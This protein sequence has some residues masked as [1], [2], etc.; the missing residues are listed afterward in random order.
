MW[1]YADGTHEFIDGEIY[2]HDGEPAS[3][4]QR[5]MDVYPQSERQEV[6]G[7]RNEEV[8]RKKKRTRKQKQRNKLIGFV[9]ELVFLAVVVVLLA[10]VM[11]FAK[12]YNKIGVESEFA[13]NSEAGINSEIESEH[14]QTLKGYTNIALFGLDNRSA[15]NYSQGRSDSIMIAS[16]NNETKEVKLVSVFRDTY[17]SV[18]NGKFR[19]ANT[20]YASGGAKQAVQMLNSNLDLNITEYVC[21]D[22]AALIEAIDALG[23]VEIEV[24]KAEVKWINSYVDEMH[25]VI[26][27]NGKHVKQ[28]GLQTLNGTQAT[29]Y[30]RIRYTSGD[31]FKRASRQRIVLGAM[32]EKAK[33]S[34]VNTLLDICEAVFDDIST[35][36]TLPEILNL[37]TGVM[38]Y[39]LTSTTGFP[40]EVTTRTI[41]GNGDTVV[42]IMLNANVSRLHEYMFGTVGYKPSASV[43]AI[44]KAI[45]QKTGVNE[46]TTPINTDKFNDTAG[47]DG[48]D[49]D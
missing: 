11:K 27:A 36:L 31:D 7:N 37:A 21:V 19:K 8:K 15:G 28:S 16:I 44:S 4:L 10:G 41:S 40:F 33:K 42:P 3:G 30:A 23:G 26:D 5:C 9:V 12:L 18:G 6:M 46:N 24:T 47:Q 48:T 32:L 13:N 17:L 20:A 2:R 39:S 38:Q 1:G 49:F 29:A 35:T 14:Q 22:W 34:N 25:K 45:V 43:E